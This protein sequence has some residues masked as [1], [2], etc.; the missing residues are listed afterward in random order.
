MDGGTSAIPVARSGIRLPEDQ[1]TNGEA[2]QMTNK[3]RST[4]LSACMAPASLSTAIAAIVAIAAIGHA[5]PVRAAAPI[6][7]LAVTPAAMPRIATVDERY[8]S[9]NIEMAEVIGGKFWKP[10]DKPGKA[11]PKPPPSAA[12]PEEAD[13]TFPQAG[14]DPALFEARPPIDLSN[15]RLRKLAAALGPAYVRVSGTWANTAYFPPAN[16]S[17]G[18]N[19]S[20]PPKGFQGVLTRPQWKGV[21]DFSQAVDAKI[22]TS[23]AISEGVRDADG[24][25][26]PDQARRFLAYTK[27]IGGEI[28][29]AEFFNEP[30]MPVYGGAPPGYD[31]AAYARDFSVFQA[32]A[33]TTAPGMRVVGPG[34]V[35]EGLAGMSLPP[36][37]TADLLAATPRPIFDVFSYHFYGAA[38]RRCAAIGEAAMTTPGAALTEEWLSRTDQ[39]YA[40]YVALHDRFEPSTPI[41]VTE[42]AD[43]ACGGNPWAVTFLDTFRYLEQ[44]GRLARR[45][46]KVIF[47]NTLAASEYGLID[48]A[49]L[50]PRPNYWA[51]L[52]WHKLMGPVVLDAGTS[53]PGLNLYAQCLRGHPGGVTLMAVNTNRAQ[54]ETLGLPLPAERYTLAAQKLEDTRVRLNGHE[55]KLEANDELPSLK[56]K[57][58]EAGPVQLAPASITFLAIADAGNAN[59]R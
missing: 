6:I 3:N 13:G 57:R 38:S 54:T 52:L 2:G 46:V 16:D 48:P 53:R 42:T 43:A 20:V 24:V 47:H 29:A 25:W 7:A 28:A 58:V 37:K 15:T 9:Y 50:K 31:A 1:T 55:L 34:S 35:G 22:V 11:A 27:S 49:T 59:C 23:F 12:M 51:A 39:G 21:V 4:V 10:Y 18:A 5:G 19:P 30:S 40:F 14:Q 56:G 32:F 26:T 17:D 45:G 44:M 41:W 8:Q 36:L 33:R